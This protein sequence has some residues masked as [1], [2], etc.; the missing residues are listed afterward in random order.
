LA[1]L[2]LLFAFA[3]LCFPLFGSATAS[4]EKAYQITEAEL[5]RL[6]EISGTQTDILINLTNTLKTLKHSEARVKEELSAALSDLAKTKAELT[7]LRQGLRNSQ[8]SLEKA[9]L[10][11]RAYEKEM[12]NRTRRLKLQRN[13]W[14]AACVA[15][16]GFAAR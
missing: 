13:I 8:N 12:K 7:L 14:F 15:V 16:L 6:E 1:K 11:L 5:T 10:S 2:P 3:L 4:A 9:N